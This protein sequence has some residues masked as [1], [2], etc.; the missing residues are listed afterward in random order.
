MPAPTG[1]F[2]VAAYEMTR[3]AV[4]AVVEHL[5]QI[6]AA[7]LAARATTAADAAQPPEAEQVQD[8]VTDAIHRGDVP[9]GP[10]PGG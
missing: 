2:A 3:G 7:W 10:L 6:H 1:F 5:P 4:A 8:A 9:G